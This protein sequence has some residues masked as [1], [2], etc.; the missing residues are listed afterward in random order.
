MSIKGQS[1]YDILL[2]YIS[3]GTDTKAKPAPI[4]DVTDKIKKIKLSTKQL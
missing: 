4:S 3:V 2:K 1:V